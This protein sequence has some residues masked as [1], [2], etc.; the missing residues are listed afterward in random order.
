MNLA[1]I[2]Y[3]KTGKEIE[4]AAR[5]QRHTIAAL[6][7]RSQ[8][9]PDAPSEFFRSTAIDCFIDFS[10]PEAVRHNIATAA[11]LHLPIVVGTTGWQ[12][13]F[14]EFIAPIKKENG[15]LLYGSNFS[16]GAQMFLRIVAR[17]SRLFNFFP[18]YD[19]AVHETH[20]RQKKDI[21]S[22]TALT[23]AKKI[24]SH[25][26]RKKR[27]TVAGDF[28]PLQKD[29]LLI[30]S[31]RVGSVFGTHR[32]LFNSP[33]DE[34]EVIHQAHNRKGFACGALLAAEWLQ[35]KTGIYRFEDVIS[36]KINSQ[37]QELS[38]HH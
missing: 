10:A 34:V 7:T 25:V 16:V 18:E 27:I 15:A 33:F 12:T 8:P 13:H 14:E 26:Q 28:S 9:L 20:H 1:L 31:S 24:L 4:H 11:A 35:T 5:E 6:F 29:D 37:Q 30:S 3:G 32:V 2:G 38:I 23:I 17:A 21:P 19:I 36:E 22:G